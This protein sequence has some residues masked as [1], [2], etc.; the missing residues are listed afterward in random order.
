MDPYRYLIKDNVVSNVFVEMCH[1]CEKPLGDDIN[2][3]LKA[4]FIFSFFV[5]TCIFS[6]LQYYLQT[7]HP[8]HLRG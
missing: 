6:R 5:K 7:N 8:F 3:Q 1:I 2:I 4:L